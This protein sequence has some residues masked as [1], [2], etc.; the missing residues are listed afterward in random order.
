MARSFADKLD[1]LFATIR[2]PDGSVWSLTDV[3]GSVN[4]A[5]QTKLSASYLSEL[6]SGRK[7]QPNIWV[8]NAL[9]QF[10]G[11]PL[12]Y[13]VEDDMEPVQPGQRRS[14]AVSAA[15]D[16]TFAS[17]LANLLRTTEPHGVGDPSDEQLARWLIQAGYNVSVKQLAQARQGKGPKPSAA[18]VGALASYLGVPAAYLTD[19]DVARAMEPQLQLMKVMQNP[20]IRRIAMRANN[21]DKSDLERVADLARRLG[22]DLEDEDLDF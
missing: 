9:A 2:R 22:A 5:G 3:V 15:D 19:P 6:R 12:E 21:L 18:L 11:Q 8:A 4:E 20:D 13:F 16:S 7:A 1:Q 10:F 17:R 14:A